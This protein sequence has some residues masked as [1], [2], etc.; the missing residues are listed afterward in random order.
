MP[1]PNAQHAVATEE[2][3]CHYLLNLSHPVGGPKAIWFLSLGYTPGNW[4]LLAADL[5]R[6]ALSC[7]DFVVKPSPYGVKYETRGE[8]SVPPHHPGR[9][10]AV[11]IAENDT[12]PRLVT[13][14]PE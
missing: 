5:R 11:W 7:E 14:Y 9:V 13:A 3:I 1:F 6:I 2:K 4:R 12:L 10:T 8:I